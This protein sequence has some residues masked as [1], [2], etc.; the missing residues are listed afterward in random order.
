MREVDYLIIGSGISGLYLSCLLADTG[1]ILLVSKEHAQ[2]SST[3]YAQ[4]GIASV[5]QSKDSFESHIRD[6]LEAGAGLCNKEAVEALV[7]E[8]PAHIQNL[9]ELGAPFARSDSG[10]LDLRQ[11]GGHSQSRIVH[12]RDWT[13][14]RIEEIL[15]RAVRR[16]KIEV[17]EYHCA[18]SLI[19]HYQRRHCRHPEREKAACFGAYIYDRRSWQVFP[20]LAKAC[21]LATG[22]AGQVYLHSTNPKVATGDGIALAYRAGA[23]IMNMEF[24]QFHP[25]TLH[26]SGKGQVFLLTEAL[27]GYGAVLRDTRGKSFLAKYDHRTELAPRDIVARAMDKELKQSGAEHLWL[28][29]THIAKEKLQEYFPNVYSRLQSE[30]LDLARDWIP[31]VPA[32]HYMCGGVQTDLSGRTSLSH[33]YA[34]GETACTGVHGSNRLASNSLLESLVFAGRIAAELKQKKQSR[35]QI[36]NEIPNWETSTKEVREWVTI[37]HN[38]EELQ[39]CMWDYVGIMRSNHRLKRALNRIKLLQEEIE[40]HYQATYIQNSLLELRNMA[41][42]ARLLVLSALHRKESRGL[43]YNI[44]YPFTGEE[45]KDTVLERAKDAMAAGA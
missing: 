36:K 29:A 31:T 25:T 4:G 22:G 45:L 23:A 37:R 20:V 43:H 38:F 26:S 30:G 24:Y 42:T 9:L 32:A 12:A 17:L 10:E 19:T 27:R 5:L 16:R 7:R 13:G 1:S 41:L 3:Y 21:I 11:E 2:E 39:Q 14:R 35:P 34:L 18:V 6:T 28:D 44:D 33:L 15:L 40:E 8:G